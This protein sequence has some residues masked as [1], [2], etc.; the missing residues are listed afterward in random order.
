MASEPTPRPM[1]TVSAKL[2]RVWTT[3]PTLAGADM[4]TTSRP[5]RTELCAVVHRLVRPLRPWS[6]IACLVHEGMMVRDGSILRKCIAERRAGPPPA[7]VSTAPGSAMIGLSLKEGGMSRPRIWIERFDPATARSE[8][9]RG[10]HALS[11]RIRAEWWPDDPPRDLPV[12]RT[13]LTTVPSVWGVRW[14]VAW[15]RGRVVGS[16]ELEMNR[17]KENRHLA[18]F[19]LSVLPEHRRQGIGSAL[20]RTVAEAARDDGRRLLGTGTA[21]TVPDGEAF[22]RWVGAQAG[23]TQEINQLA[24]RDVDPAL[25]RAWQ[26]RAPAEAFRLGFWEGPYPEADL[27]EVVA[28][29]DVMNTAPRGDLDME[30]FHWT[31]AL[32][33]DQEESMRKRGVERWTVYARHT[34]TGRIAGFTEVGWNRNEPEILHQWG[35]GVFP[36]FRNHGLGRWL[37]AAMLA[38]VLAG[39]PQV[40]FVRTGNANS[41]APMLN[42]NHKLGFRLY[43]TITVWQV[44]VGRVLSS[45]AERGK[46]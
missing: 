18:W 8:A 23:L 22:L 41:N 2:Y 26:D 15:H 40:K 44:P 24:I 19:D 3:S 42:I 13:V 10:Y 39:R 30:D 35:T 32:I 28:M 34:S 6:S 21:I 45:L 7:R 37:K 36:E 20:L 29:H 25:L 17:T 4:R 31:P 38:K 11:N 14:W 43:N 16:A 1:K 5:L 33:R 12:L 46:G 9:M 27:A